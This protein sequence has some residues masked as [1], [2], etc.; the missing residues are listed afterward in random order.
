MVDSYASRS[1]LVARLQ[2]REN[3]ASEGDVDVLQYQMEFAD[4]LT[5]VEREMTLFVDTEVPAEIESCI[6]SIR[7]RSGGLNQD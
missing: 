5:P 6:R 4:T 2:D 1:V 3:D 7:D